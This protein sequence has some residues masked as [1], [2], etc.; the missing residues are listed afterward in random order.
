MDRVITHLASEFASPFKWAKE[1]EESKL[2]KEGLTT[3]LVFSLPNFDKSFN[4]ECD[5][6]G[7]G[8][9]AVLSFHSEKLNEAR[10]K[11]SA[12]EQELYDDVQAMK[13][14]MLVH[15]CVNVFVCQEGKGKAQNTGLYMPLPV[16]ESPRVNI[17]M[18]FVLGIPRTQGGVDCKKNVQANYMVEEVQ[19]TQ[20][21]VRAKIAADKRCRVKLLKEDL[22]NTSKTSNFLTFMSFTPIMKLKSCIKVALDF[23]SPENVGEC[24]RLTED[25]RVLPQNHR[26][27]EDKLEIYM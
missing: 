21:V 14:W 25:F 20:E 19:A 4:L 12:N 17:P 27:K 26:A 24:I 2:T 9:E 7:T 5:A 18:D 3:A 23:V 10:Q 6:C 13:K 11:W 22:P 1:A 15:L 16:P 8:I